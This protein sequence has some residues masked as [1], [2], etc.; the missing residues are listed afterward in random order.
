MTSSV[1]Y[2][3]SPKDKDLNEVL[4]DSDLDSDSDKDINTMNKVT[5]YEVHRRLGY[6][7]KAYIA[8]TL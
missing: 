1:L 3:I 5:A 8:S 6:T 4:S 7:G 2:L